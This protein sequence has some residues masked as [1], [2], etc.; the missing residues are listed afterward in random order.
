MTSS[1]VPHGSRT[2]AVVRHP[3]AAVGRDADLCGVV[4]VRYAVR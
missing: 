4:G 1:A 2:G 3:C